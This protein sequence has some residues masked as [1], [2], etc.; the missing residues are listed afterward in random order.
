MRPVQMLL[1]LGVL[2]MAEQEQGMTLRPIGFVH[3]QVKAT[4]KF[5]FKEMVSEI[6]IEPSF[7]E[8]LDNLEEFSHIIVLYWMHLAD[9]QPPAKIHPK[10]RRELSLVGLFAT[11]SPD[12]PNPIGKATVELLE[13]KG[14]LLR[15]KGL[16]AI[17][18]TPVVDIKP[19]LPHNDCVDNARV[20]GWV[21]IQ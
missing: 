20:P 16:D 4:G 9:R 19:Y 14:N 17:D 10:G 12:R 11:R 13:K 2:K 8:A 15:V 6:I 3:N 1:C 5:D 21:N 7:S 18:G